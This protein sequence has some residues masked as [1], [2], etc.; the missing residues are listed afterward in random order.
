MSIGDDAANGGGGGGD[1]S[2]PAG[3]GAAQ[4]FP[5]RSGQPSLAPQRFP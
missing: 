3:G 5:A 4:T 1:G 2:G